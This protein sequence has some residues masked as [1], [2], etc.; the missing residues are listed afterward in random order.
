MQLAKGKSA[1]YC[2]ATNTTSSRTYSSKD[3]SYPSTNLSRQ[4]LTIQHNKPWNYL[5]ITGI[6]MMR[7]TFRGPCGHNFNLYSK[8][9]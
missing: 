8:K 7:M 4:S 5:Q 3:V 1:T 2:P 6:M 9:T